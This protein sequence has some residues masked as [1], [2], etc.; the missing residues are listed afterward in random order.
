MNARQQLAPTSEQWRAV[1]RDI[2]E[3]NAAEHRTHAEN[4]LVALDSLKIRKLHNRLSRERVCK[5]EAY[6]E[7]EGYAA[8][9]SFMAKM[10]HAYLD[11]L[12]VP[13]EECDE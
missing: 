11:A 7:K 5:L 13:R 9:Y 8:E 2:A 6:F 1:L 3:V 10:A 12:G 4:R